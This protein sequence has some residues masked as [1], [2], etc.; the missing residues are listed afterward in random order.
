MQEAKERIVKWIALNDPTK[1]LNLSRLNLK[2]LPEIPTNCQTLEC[3]NNKLT[4]LPELSN[5][6]ILFCYNNQYLWINKKQAKQFGIKETP[7][8]SKYAKMIQRNYKRY[9]IKK[10]HLLDKYLLKNTIKVV[11][12]YI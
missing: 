6:Q 3:D 10:Y 9:I 5:C 4:V 7:N 12:L 2:E 8:Y 11:I 1:P